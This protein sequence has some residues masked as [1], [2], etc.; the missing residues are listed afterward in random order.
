MQNH[1]IATNIH[2]DNHEM[3]QQTLDGDV[4]IKNNIDVTSVE[5]ELTRSANC[6]T[7]D[8]NIGHEEQTWSMSGHDQPSVGNNSK[9][10]STMVT[11]LF[12]VAA[13]TCI[14]YSISLIGTFITMFAIIFAV[15][16]CP[17]TNTNLG[18]QLII[19][20]ESFLTSL[21][22]ILHFFFAHDIY[23]YVFGCL[24]RRI[25]IWLSKL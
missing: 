7:G 17:G 12:N 11:V 21:C 5:L 3:G 4:N 24:D 10:N 8:I 23:H 1:H 14:L 18:A 13:M 22:V 20:V 6:D 16:I 19:E 15:I 25:K 9:P 2:N